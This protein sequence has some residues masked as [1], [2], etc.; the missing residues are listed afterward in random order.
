MGL[1]KVSNE[2]D[3]RHEADYDLGDINKRWGKSPI[4][5]ESYTSIW[6]ETL[7]VRK[8]HRRRRWDGQHSNALRWARHGLSTWIKF[9]AIEDDKV[10]GK[11]VLITPLSL[12]CVVLI[13]LLGYTSLPPTSR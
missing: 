11:A 8:H 1:Q 10:I 6:I 2:R 3:F 5:H 4:D 13:R 7:V 12:R 9:C